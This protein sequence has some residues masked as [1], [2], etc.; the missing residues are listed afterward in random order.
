[1][2]FERIDQRVE[3]CGGSPDPVGE[4]RAGKSN[5]LAR[6]D[7][8]LSIKRQM[9]GI[10]GDQHMR[11]EASAGTRARSASTAAVPARYARRRDS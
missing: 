8:R 11:E 5:A 10:F 4:C 9:V 3:Q 7:R 6:I 1:M 2:A